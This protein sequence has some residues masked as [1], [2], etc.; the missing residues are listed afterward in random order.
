MAQYVAFKPGI[1]VIGQSMLSV[2][3]AMGSFVSFAR[4]L[5]HEH[6]LTEIHSA[7]WYP[8]QPYLDA[9]AAIASH[10]GEE[11]LFM[12]GKRVP[13]HALWPSYVATLEDALASIDIAYHMN[14]RVDGEVMYD[15]AT[16]CMHEGIGHYRCHKEQPRRFIMVCEN[17]YPSE[18]DRGLITTIARKFRPLASVSLD[19]VKPSRKHGA[20]SCTY[21]VSW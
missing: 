20:N 11:T 21:I 8:R 15:A 9:F 4:Q 1:E 10:I 14:H 16:C 7:A 18:F 19:E 3:D 2:L 17:P 13:E 5:L 12:I 6:G